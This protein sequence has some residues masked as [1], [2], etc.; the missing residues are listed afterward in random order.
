MIIDEITKIATA[1]VANNRVAARLQSAEDVALQSVTPSLH[2]M[3]FMFFAAAPAA[4]GGRSD[5][6]SNCP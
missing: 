4:M 2:C 6:L 5:T 3:R 1:A